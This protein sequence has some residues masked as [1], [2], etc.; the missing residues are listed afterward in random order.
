M[1]LIE[2]LVAQYQVL[3]VQRVCNDTELYN[4]KDEMNE[5]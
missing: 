5:R 2:I 3:T 4:G 1:H